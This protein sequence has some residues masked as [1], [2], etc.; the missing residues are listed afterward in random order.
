MTPTGRYLAGGINIQITNVSATKTVKT[1]ALAVTAITVEGTGADIA[2]RV[3][4]PV[5]L[6]AV[7]PAAQPAEAVD[8]RVA[9]ALLVRRD[10]E[11]TKALRRELGKPAIRNLASR[12]V[13]I[14]CREAEAL[15]LRCE[16][17]LEDMGWGGASGRD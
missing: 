11:Y 16:G 6:R 13:S 7:L 10:N 15:R 14:T 4:H 1:P 3:A 8:L 5:V 2:V 17:D 9:V 12:I